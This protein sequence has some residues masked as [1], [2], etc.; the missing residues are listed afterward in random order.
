MKCTY[1]GGH[2]QQCLYLDIARGYKMLTVVGLIKSEDIITGFR[3]INN[4]TQEIMDRQERSYNN[5][6]KFTNLK[7]NDI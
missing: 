4:I 3:V 6:L 7:I 1:S 2:W 5:I